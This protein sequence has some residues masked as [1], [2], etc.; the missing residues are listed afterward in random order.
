MANHRQ[1]IIS[2]RDERLKL[3][4]RREQ[5]REESV[6]LRISQGELSERLTS[7][8]GAIEALEKNSMEQNYLY[9]DLVKG[10]ELAQERLSETAKLIENVKD[11]Q[12]DIREENRLLTE[13]LEAVVRQIGLENERLGGE[14]TK[15]NQRHDR[16]SESRSNIDKYSYH[17]ESLEGK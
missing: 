2:L 3:V 1:N 8:K 17:V 16:L 10:G 9:S 5:Y 11:E 12:D 7:V 13:E 14:R 4:A 6:Q 15:M